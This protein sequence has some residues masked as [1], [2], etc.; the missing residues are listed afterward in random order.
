[1]QGDMQRVLGRN[2]RAHRRALGLTQE[3][4]ASTLGR[5]RTHVGAI[6]R[7][8]ENMTLQAI[9]RLAEDLGVHPLTLLASPEPDAEPGTPPGSPDGR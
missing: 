3:R 9:E 2:V 1:M 8:E 5:N 7:G 6:E 4:L